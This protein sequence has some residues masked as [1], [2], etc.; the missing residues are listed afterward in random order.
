MR[1]PCQVPEPEPTAAE[2]IWLALQ[3]SED[4]CSAHSKFLCPLCFPEP[5]L[6]AS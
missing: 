6:D 3:V 4:T 5:G 2:E 1:W